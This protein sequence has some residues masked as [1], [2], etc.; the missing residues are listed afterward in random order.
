VHIPEHKWSS[1]GID[2]INQPSVT[3][4]GHNSIAVFVDRLSKRVRLEPCDDTTSAEEFAEVF[5]R[6]IFKQYGYLWA[7]FR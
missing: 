3:F 7:L 2:F 5:L 6:A 4:T 1:I